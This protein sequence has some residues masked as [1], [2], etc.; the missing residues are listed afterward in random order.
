MIHII[1]M[2]PTSFA[3][4]ALYEMQEGNYTNATYI[5]GSMEEAVLRLTDN[6]VCANHFS[7]I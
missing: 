2:W 5:W 7:C 3:D 6:V 1:G 4:S